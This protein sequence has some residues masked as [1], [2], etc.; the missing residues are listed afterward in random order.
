MPGVDWYAFIRDRKPIYRSESLCVKGSNNQ[1]W[2]APQFHL[3]SY[4]STILRYSPSVFPSSA[5]LYFLSA[6]FMCY[7]QS[8]LTPQILRILL[9]CYCC[10]AIC[11]VLPIRW[12]RGQD[13]VFEDAASDSTTDLLVLFVLAPGVSG[14]F[15]VQVLLITRLKCF[16]QTVTEQ[17]LPA[18]QGKS[19]VRKADDSL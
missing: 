11:D 15:S 13:T 4:L 2:N 10:H 9:F 1:W 8:L 5:T 7:I 18:A 6:T 3:L 16:V 12:W 19:S 14:R 17:N